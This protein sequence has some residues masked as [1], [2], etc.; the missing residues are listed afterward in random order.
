M[1][2]AV[3]VPKVTLTVG[4]LSSSPFVLLQRI[5]KVI[6]FEDHSKFN[7]EDDFNTLYYLFYDPNKVESR[8]S[9]ESRHVLTTISKENSIFTDHKM[10]I[11]DT[12]RLPYDVRCKT[13]SKAYNHVFIDP[14][15]GEPRRPLTNYVY[16]NHQREM[17]KTAAF[18]L[19][20]F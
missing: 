1:T 14:A 20:R 16:E 8:I 9:D 13:W 7:S 4:R 18:L 12:P 3:T 2:Q 17:I 15:S 19:G 10:R 11:K 6:Q 5:S